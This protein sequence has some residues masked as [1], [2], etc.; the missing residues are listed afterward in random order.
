MSIISLTKLGTTLQ[1]KRKS[2]NLTT[3][4]LAKKLGV[5]V[6]LISNIEHGKTDAFKLDL[7]INLL[8][9][10]DISSIQI[11]SDKVLQ[12]NELNLKPSNNNIE[13]NI[14]NEALE[15]SELIKN[16]LSLINN[17]FLKILYK[18]NYNPKT[19]KLLSKHIIREINF[20]DDIGNPL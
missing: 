17:S 16:E 1:T 14:N 10:L 5:S 19:V 4:K 13:I 8:N 15:Q 18:Y 11:A 6:G 3:E 12:I 9:T 7:L 20:L 2:K